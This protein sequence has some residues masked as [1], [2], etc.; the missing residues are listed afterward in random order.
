MIIA[1]NLHKQLRLA[2]LIDLVGLFY[3]E[4][5]NKF[6]RFPD[7]YSNEC[8]EEILHLNTVCYLDD[9]LKI[10]NGEEV[11]SEFVLQ[12]NLDFICSGDDFTLTYDY[13]LEHQGSI[14]KVIFI[15]FL[16]FYL[17]NDTF[18]E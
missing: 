16:N 5:G 6:D 10:E 2:E 9:S 17:E 11:Y 7:L 15:E 14:S 4:V 18:P 12:H 1:E 3:E 13:L 8:N